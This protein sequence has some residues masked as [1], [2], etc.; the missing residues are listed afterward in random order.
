MRGDFLRCHCAER[1][2]IRASRTRRRFL[3]N[4][5]PMC[6]LSAAY[7]RRRRSYKCRFRYRL[8]SRRPCRAVLLCP[9][10]PSVILSAI[11]ISQIAA[12]G[13]LFADTMSEYNKKK[14]AQYKKGKTE[15]RAEKKIKRIPRPAERIISCGEKSHTGKERQKHHYK[16]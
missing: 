4:P 9:C 2:C 16:S 8:C 11:I 6:F 12:G 10:V 14:D 7:T 1:A 5:I 13:K 3:E 15:Y